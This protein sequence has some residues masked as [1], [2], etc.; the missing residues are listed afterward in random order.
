MQTDK[1]YDVSYKTHNQPKPPKT[2][3]NYPKPP[4]T[5]WYEIFIPKVEKYFLL[6]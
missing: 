4:T 1:V 5:K 6:I 3:N 2:T